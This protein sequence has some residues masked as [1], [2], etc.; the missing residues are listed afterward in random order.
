MV[1]TFLR[2]SGIRFDVLFGGF[3]VIFER[4]FTYFSMDA[5]ACCLRTCWKRLLRTFGEFLTWYIT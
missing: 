3:H 5:L 4:C 2:S 1:V